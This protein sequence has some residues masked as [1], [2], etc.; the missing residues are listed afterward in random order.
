VNWE[1]SG[2]P[3]IDLLLTF[4]RYLLDGDA[5]DALFRD[6][7]QLAPSWAARLTLRPSGSFSK[8]RVDIPDGVE[9]VGGYVQMAV[10]MRGP[11]YGRMVD[12]LKA[13]GEPVKERVR[14]GT[15]IRGRN[16][17]L[18]GVVEVDADP[19]SRRRGRL[20]SNNDITLQLEGERFERRVV[21]DWALEAMNALC[22]DLRPAWAVTYD[23]DEWDAKVM[24]HA[25]GLSAVGVD[26]SRF[27][28]GLFAWN[29]FGRPY[30]DLI[31][32]DRLLTAPATDVRELGAGVF[33]RLVDDPHR[34]D[35]SESTSASERALE[36]VGPE[37]FFSI[38]HPEG[39]TKSADWSR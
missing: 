23:I 39:P 35:S 1:Q 27:L 20:L 33:L 6:L 26:F 30:V 34:W 22:L 5:M 3:R 36:H 24:S 7:R 14:G 37:Y 11:A 15:E 32:R 10:T 12:Q 9:A 28:P 4:D 16:N 17:G 18:I 19:M 21:A 31:G 13:A 29:Y 38:Q 2:K 25:G 8:E